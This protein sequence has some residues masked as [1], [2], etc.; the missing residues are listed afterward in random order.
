M[1]KPENKSSAK[2]SEQR[3][4]VVIKERALKQLSKIPKK[5]AEKIDALIRSLAENPRPSGCK[6]LQGY[7]NAYRVRYSDYRIVYTIE[8]NKLI[9]DVIQIGDRKD[10]YDSF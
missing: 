1:K 7:A 6:K 2:Q 4:K 8:D 3:Y 5:F 10:V 9:V